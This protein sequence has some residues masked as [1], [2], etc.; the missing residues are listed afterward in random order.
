LTNPD[1]GADVRVDPAETI[2]AVHE[3]STSDERKTAVLSL[4]ELIG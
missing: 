3:A 2:D 4:M 1:A